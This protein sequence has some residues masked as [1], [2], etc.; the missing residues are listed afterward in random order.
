MLQCEG[1][2]MFRGTCMFLPSLAGVPAKSFHGTWLYNP[3][4]NH[5]YL[6]G[7]PD[8]PYGTSFKADRI[9]IV[10]DEG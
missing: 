6:N 3:E 1:Y 7:C 4:N 2:K 5:W 9:L 10:E 8:Y